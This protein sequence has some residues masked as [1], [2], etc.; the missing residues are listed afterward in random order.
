MFLNNIYLLYYNKNVPITPL[1][2]AEKDIMGVYLLN[3][4][5]KGHLWVKN[6]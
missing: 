3:I 4:V 2:L 5:M 1:F 6:Y